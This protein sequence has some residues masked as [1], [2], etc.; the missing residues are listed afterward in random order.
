[1]KAPHNG[2][3]PWVSF[4]CQYV[5]YLKGINATKFP[6]NYYTKRVCFLYE[7]F[8]VSEHYCNNQRFSHNTYKYRVSLL[9]ELYHAFEGNWT[10]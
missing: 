7:S 5:M 4:Q 6:H 8:H 1:M 2:Y 9:S 3:K 10:K